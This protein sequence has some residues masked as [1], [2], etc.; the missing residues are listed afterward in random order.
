MH[1]TGNAECSRGG[2]WVGGGWLDTVRAGPALKAF[3]WLEPH[4]A[5]ICHKGGVVGPAGGACAAAWGMRTDGN[6]LWLGVVPGLR[7]CM[8]GCALERQP[9]QKAARWL[10]RARA[11]SEKQVASFYHNKAA[12][13]GPGLNSTRSTM[14]IPFLCDS[15]ERCSG[16]LLLIECCKFLPPPSRFC[17][18]LHHSP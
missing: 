7:A 9:R 4:R 16:S 10:R 17:V 1:A 3:A 5:G 14:L 8:R 12:R 15:A 13:L 11:V 2:G 6:A 18:L